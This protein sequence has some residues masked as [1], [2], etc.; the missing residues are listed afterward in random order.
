MRGQAGKDDLEGSPVLQAPC[1][2]PEGSS[3]G[4]VP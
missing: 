2:A 3:P 4:S 1:W